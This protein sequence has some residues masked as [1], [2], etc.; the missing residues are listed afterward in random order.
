MKTAI[1]LPDDLFVLAE[2]FSK[3]R[4]LKRSEL[5]VVALREY[6]DAHRHDGLTQ[7]INQACAELEGELPTGIAR[8]ARKNLLEAEW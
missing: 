1:S 2:E 8:V 3:A 5:Y 7:K 4:G 6:I